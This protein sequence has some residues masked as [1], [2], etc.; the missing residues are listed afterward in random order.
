MKS[1]GRGPAVPGNPEM[2]EEQESSGSADG[3]LKAGPAPPQ[4]KGSARKECELGKKSEC[5]K[6]TSMTLCQNW[7]ARPEPTHAAGICW[8]LR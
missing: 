7:G 5:W 2:V 1:E 6:A 4:G 8:G 3:E